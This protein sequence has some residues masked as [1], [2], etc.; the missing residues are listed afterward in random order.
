MASL[1]N[2]ASQLMDRQY[3]IVHS[4][5]DGKYLMPS[6]FIF[7]TI[8]KE[9]LNSSVFIDANSMFTPSPFAEKVHFQH[10]AKFINH[11]ITKK[12]NYSLQ[13]SQQ[14]HMPFNLDQYILNFNP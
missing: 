6:S 9:H 13:V 5:A 11:L 14:L 2:R 10:T 4:T 7:A 8:V 12:A 3:M 1:T